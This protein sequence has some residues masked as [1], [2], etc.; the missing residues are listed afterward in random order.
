MF[1]LSLSEV[2]V[3]LLGLLTIIDRILSAVAGVREPNAKQDSAI[4][5]IN[6][7]LDQQ[8]QM[9]TAIS[10]QLS[11]LRDNHLAHLSEDVRLICERLSRLEGH[12]DISK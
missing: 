2:L 7:R 3:V 4:L 9:L 11:T 6:Q 8:S 1:G 12:L 10:S 5:L